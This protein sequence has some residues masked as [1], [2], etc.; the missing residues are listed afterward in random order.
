MHFFYIDES[1]SRD[2]QDDAH[3]YFVLSAVGVADE[4]WSFADFLL[5]M[6][7]LEGFN[8]HDIEI[9]STWLRNPKAQQLNYLIPASLS[10]D[11][12]S[13]A[14]DNIYNT[15]DE[16]K[17]VCFACVIDKVR[18][19]QELFHVDYSPG[20]LRLAYLSLIGM[21]IN[22]LA[23][24]TPPQLGVL[25]HDVIDNRATQANTVHK[26]LL[27]FQRD[28][29]D[30][31]WFKKL[32]LVSEEEM[33]KLTSEVSRGLMKQ[34]LDRPIIENAQLIVGGIHFMPSHQAVFLQIA[35]LL[36]YNVLRQ[37][38]EHGKEWRSGKDIETTE[39]YEYFSKMSPKFR[40]S[41]EGSLKDF[42]LSHIP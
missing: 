9:K 12:L 41:S 27:D 32:G 3:P 42:G 4:D 19:R 34:L 36:A 23:S 11:E 33:S 18:L 28:S 20:L 24:F 5:N 25:V 15:L 16:L 21:I 22:F 29:T 38:Q 26:Y 30:L 6:T 35:D 37:F 1:G 2:L 39:Q 13:Q 10:K 7:R 17:I 40:R 14:V 8:K 31:I